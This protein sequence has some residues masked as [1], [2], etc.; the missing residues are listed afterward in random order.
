MFPRVREGGGDLV[1]RFG[2]FL[3]A[4]PQGAARAPGARRLLS[5][6]V[7]DARSLEYSSITNA[8]PRGTLYKEDGRVV[9][10][11]ATDEGLCILFFHA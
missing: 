11:P 1:P 7:S 10:F 9:V 6:L 4:G 8:P 3:D 2:P 5:E